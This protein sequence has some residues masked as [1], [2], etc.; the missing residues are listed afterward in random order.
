MADRKQYVYEDAAETA[1]I[2]VPRPAPDWRCDECATLNPGRELNC[3]Y[4]GVLRPDDDT[5]PAPRD[6]SS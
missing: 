4:C 2:S 3:N 1:V 6:C 5:V